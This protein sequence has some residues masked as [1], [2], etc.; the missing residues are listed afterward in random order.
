MHAPP[1]Y[2]NTPHR[3]SGSTPSVPYQHYYCRLSCY[4][5]FASLYYLLRHIRSLWFGP[6]CQHTLTSTQR[7]CHNAEK[8]QTKH[9]PLQLMMIIWGHGKGGW[10]KELEKE[11]Q[12]TRQELLLMAS[13]GE[14]GLWWHN[15]NVCWW[16]PVGWYVRATG[17]LVHC[18]N[19]SRGNNNELESD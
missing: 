10:A 17:I 14:N 16:Q 4:C 5:C 7:R 18:N 15:G 11:R 9:L 2:S 13:L 19:A 8:T 6:T 12:T 1:T 3:W